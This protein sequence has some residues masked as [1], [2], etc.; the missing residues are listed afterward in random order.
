MTEMAPDS[1]DMKWHLDERPGGLNRVVPSLL[2]LLALGLAVSSVHC[3]A[4][5]PMLNSVNDQ[6]QTPIPGSGHDYQHM[7]NETVNYAN[8]SVNFDITFPTPKGRGI[9]LPYAWS[10]NS[11]TVNT[12]NSVDGNTPYW[13]YGPAYDN[14]GWNTSKGIPQASVQVF[15]QTPPTGPPGFTL[16]PCNYQSGMTFTDTSGVQ[17]NLN[18]AAFAAQ[19]T[20]QGNY[21]STCGDAQ[22]VLPPG[23]DG[24]VAA[25]IWPSTASNDLPGSP[26]T[27]PFI[28]EDKDGTIYTFLWSASEGSGSNTHGYM[29]SIED[30]NGNYIGFP[31]Q[32][33]ALY[34]DTLGRPGPIGSGNSLTIENQT[35]TATW[36]TSSSNFPVNYQGGGVSPT[37]CEPFPGTVTGNHATL[38]VLK[39]PNGQEFQ[40]FYGSYGLLT[41]IIYPDGGWVKYTWQLS[42]TNNEEASMGGLVEE[43]GQNG[44]PYYNQVAYG[45]NWAYQTPVIATRTVSFDGTHTAQSQQ[46]TFNTTWAYSDGQINGWTQKTATVITTDNVRNLTSKVV[47]T[48]TPLGV[49]TQPFQN[50]GIATMIPVESTIQYYDWGQGTLLKQVS[51]T[52]LDQFNLASEATT[53]YG[54]NNVS[55]TSKT[56]Y[57]YTSGLCANPALSSFVYL[58]EQDDYDFGQGTDSSPTVGPLTKK[59]IY[60]YHCFPAA[61][62]ASYNAY[63]TGPWNDYTG[64]ML[65][66]RVSSVTTENGSGTIVAATQYGYDGT[67]PSSVTPVQYDQ[68][69]N[70]VTIRG[71]LTSVTKCTTLPSSPTSSCTG[72]TTNYAY[73]YSGQPTSMSD[74]N[75]NTTHFSFADEFTD[76][77]SKNT[78]A[79]LTNITYASPE[80]GVT[81]QE[82]FKYS[83][84]TGFLTQS[85]DE[86]SNVTG[87]TYSDPLDRLTEISYPDTGQT[88][89]TYNDSAACVVRSILLNTANQLQTS[90]ICRDGMFHTITSQVTSDPDS[91]NSTDTV[92]TVYDGEGLVYTKT[93]PYRPTSSATDGTTTSYYDALG[94]PIET[95]KQDGSTVQMCYDGVPS[96]PTVSYCSGGQLGSTT[97]HGGPG[98]RVDTTDERGNHWQHVSDGLGRLTQVMEPNGATQTPTMETDY[99]YDLLN[100]LLSV[101]QWGGA[102][103]SSGARTRAFSYDNISRLL[104]SGNPETGTI[105]YSYYQGGSSLCSGDPSLPCSR[106]DARGI[107]TTYAYDAVNRLTLKTYS[108]GTY[109]ANYLYDDVDQSPS[110]LNSLG[111]LSEVSNT[112]NNSVSYSYDTMGRPQ[113]TYYMLPSVCCNHANQ[114]TTTVTYDLAGRPTQITYPDGRVVKETWNTASHLQTVQYAQ[115][116]GTNVNYNYLSSATYWP[117]GA[118]MTM[119]LGSGVFETYSRNRRLQPVEIL[120]AKGSTKLFDKQICY[121]PTNDPAAPFCT[122]AA[123]NDGGDITQILD[124]LNSNNTQTFTYDSL[125]RL[126]TFANTGNTMQQTFSID[127]WG[128]LSQSG[129]VSSVLTFGT[130]NRI[131]TGGYGYDGS[132]NLNSFYNG[133]STTTYAYDAEDRIININSGA[134]TYVYSASGDRVRKNVGSSWTEYAHFAGQPLS[135]KNS[136]GTWTDYVFANGQRIAMAASNDESNPTATTN[137]YTSDQIGSAR[138]ITN[139]SGG[140]L[141]SYIFY[142]FGQGAQPDENHY[143]FTGK[144][145]DSES[146]LDNFGAR[147]LTSN[148]GRFM[149]PDWSA[150]VEPVPYSELDNPQSLNLYSYVLNNPIYQADADGHAPLGLGG[151]ENCASNNSSDDCKGQTVADQ[152]KRE[153]EADKASAQQK[154][155]TSKGTG[156]LRGLGQRFKNMFTGH[157]FKTNMELTPVVTH[158]LFY[159]VSG[160]YNFTSGFMAYV[161]ST[162]DL[163]TGAG[164]GA[165]DG[166]AAVVGLST[167]PEGYLKGWSGTGCGFAGVGGCYGKSPGGPDA[168]MLGPGFGGWGASYT[169]GTTVE[170]GE[171]KDYEPATVKMGD[172]YF[173]DEAG[174]WSTTVNH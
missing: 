131:T 138:L 162:G 12:L 127:P 46:F 140:L 42:S 59:T 116:N 73:D 65:T 124:T 163:I 7:L 58:Q 32:N 105:T 92:T 6:T 54:S 134:D 104:S 87:Y 64:V 139:G 75:N 49:P 76:S 129:T 147:Y 11:G 155:G 85:E 174:T 23:G 107:V 121:G 88:S 25:T 45:C 53:I 97:P 50:S 96:S 84:T 47:Y 13:N 99:S 8:G 142:P 115:W 171:V 148:M 143:L 37:I 167:D 120:A 153:H 113:I 36:G 90:Q 130:N 114:V 28:I 170:P 156:F 44:Q 34:T 166:A 43:M 93:N 102:Y 117:D 2:V 41:E 159:E 150:K 94:R 78:N 57:S 149:T 141:S 77:Q 106:T 26:T 18:T 112:H 10:Y 29:Q 48:Y 133:V 51:K 152:M 173:D 63:N 56:T 74:P 111:R 165:G 5:V 169:W 144:E 122:V 22:V 35:Y 161:P 128:N 125:N 1:T 168:Y 118:P 52:W 71:N 33:G 86:N 100:D 38:Q 110:V 17:H 61:H 60:N 135:E 82:N 27:G 123:G 55:L 160:T 3:I 103:N 89:Y 62:V 15:T 91:Q 132:G 70:T 79:Y 9:S 137:Y 83:Y 154:S 21:I 145:R 119:G 68:N 164:P 109:P 80:S 157:G 39:L 95:M 158:K 101:T 31:G 20:I 126:A 146:G 66:P 16:L 30:R 67:A 4:Q 172:A 108:D 24:Q 69:Y 136:N 19:E 98:T 40:F 151:F 14:D 81:L 72:L